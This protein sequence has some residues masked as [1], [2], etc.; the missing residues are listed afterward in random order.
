VI[1]SIIRSDHRS[2]V[3]VFFVLFSLLF[4]MTTNYIVARFKILISK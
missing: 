2:F 4:F 3:Y 1:D